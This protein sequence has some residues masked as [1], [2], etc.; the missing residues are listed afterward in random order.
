M[1]TESSASPQCTDHVINLYFILHRMALKREIFR[2]S[3]L[4]F[5]YTDQFEKRCENNR[6]IRS[7]S[8]FFFPFQ[9]FERK[10]REYS[11]RFWLFLLVYFIFFFS[12]IFFFFRKLKVASVFKSSFSEVTDW[13]V[14]HCTDLFIFL[15]KSCRS[16]LRLWNSSLFDAL[17]LIFP[18]VISYWSWW[19]SKYYFQ[20]H[21]CQLS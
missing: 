6:T 13:I 11:A 18:A 20:I 2:T 16:F 9:N 4:P 3:N 8:W 10:G 17:I 21:E 19:E 12:D 15:P 7:I 14:L 1:L 5:P